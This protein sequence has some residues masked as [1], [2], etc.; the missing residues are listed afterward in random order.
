MAYLCEPEQGTRTELFGIPDSQVMAS[1][2]HW[3]WRMHMAQE[4]AVRLDAEKFGVKNLYLF[5]STTSG[6]AGP[7]SDIDLLVHVT[8][9]QHQQGAAVG[10]HYL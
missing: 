4:I 1:R 6:A 9:S 2:D 5:G 10:R 3:R 8:G 7:G